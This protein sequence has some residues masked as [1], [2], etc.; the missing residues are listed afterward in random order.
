VGRVRVLEV[1]RKDFQGM[2]AW[3]HPAS[4]AV[5]KRLALLVADRL[6][7]NMA[8]IAHVD[9]FDPPPTTFDPPL[10]AAHRGCSFRWRDF[11]PRLPFFADMTAGDL[12]RF[13]SITGG[14]VFQV[15]RGTT[16]LHAGAVPDRCYLLLRGAIE[17]RLVD[18]RGSR[19][20]EVLGPGRAVG[21]ASLLLGCERSGQSIAR[22]DAVLLELPRAAFEALTG[23]AHRVSFKFL[24]ALTRGL[25]ERMCHATRLVSRLEHERF[26]GREVP[27]ADE[28]SSEHLWVR[29]QGGAEVLVVDDSAMNRAILRTRLEQMG[30]LP[31]EAIDGEDALRILA[32][33]RFDAIL[34]D[35]RMPR[36]DGYETLAHLK[37]TPELAPIPVIMITAVEGLDSAIRCLRLG[38]EDYLPRLFED[39][40]LRARLDACLE[41]GHLRG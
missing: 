38:A 15:P 9:G 11:L 40:V 13:V 36:L 28:A 35:V 30:H 2:L 14:E 8:R 7:E 27:H 21:E 39:G 24:G 33:Q 23:D 5:M 29:R 37:A 6:R 18:P 1:D 25:I 4:F 34:L 31:T 20:L 3:F 22:E 16:V 32:G 41:R 12:D 19:R 17:R 10:D 26:A